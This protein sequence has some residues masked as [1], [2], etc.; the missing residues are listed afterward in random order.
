[1]VSSL[2]ASSEQVD[3]RYVYRFY[4]RTRIVVLL[5]VNG[6]VTLE[7]AWL[8]IASKQNWLWFGV[9]VFFIMFLYNGWVALLD[10]QNKFVITVSQTGIQVPIIWK[11][12]SKAYFPFSSIHAIELIKVRK[13]TI[14]KLSMGKKIYVIFES[15]FAQRQDFKALLGILEKQTQI[16]VSGGS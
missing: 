9:F 8:A 10:A 3:A 7:F 12:E 14:L 4:S 5:V 15:Y 1:M 16:P 6:L 2:T 13:D 11:R